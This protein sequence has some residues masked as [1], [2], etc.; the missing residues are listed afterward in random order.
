MAKVP[1]T[2]EV[3]QNRPLR[4]LVLESEASPTEWATV[5]LDQ[6]LGRIHVVPEPALACGGAIALRTRVERNEGGDL[7]HG[8]EECAAQM[9][10]GPRQSACADGDVAQIEGVGKEAVLPIVRGKGN[11]E[12]ID[13]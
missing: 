12:R 11:H 10:D 4:N 2:V 7:Q 5:P 9:L 8:P 3:P 1:C 6:P 13:I